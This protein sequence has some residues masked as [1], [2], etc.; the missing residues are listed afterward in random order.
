METYYRRHASPDFY[1][2]CFPQLSGLPTWILSCSSSGP[3]TVPA[4]EDSGKQSLPSGPPCSEGRTYPKA[5]GEATKSCPAAIKSGDDANSYSLNSHQPARQDK[6]ARGTASSGV[7][8][9]KSRQQ[10]AAAA[11]SPAA[12]RGRTG[13]QPRRASTL[14]RNCFI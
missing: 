11:P 14:D 2:V 3:I 5:K 7:F 1:V 9:A 4:L 12:R 13:R 6:Y 8:G 10:T